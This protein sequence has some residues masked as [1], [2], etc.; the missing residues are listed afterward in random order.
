MFIGVGQPLNYAINNYNTFLSGYMNGVIQ[1]ISH[2][3][4]LKWV[5]SDV[6][7]DNIVIKNAEINVSKNLNGNLQKTKFNYEPYVLQGE[8]KKSVVAI[9]FGSA[10]SKI[11]LV[12]NIQKMYYFWMG[13]PLS[14][15]AFTI[16]LLTKFED[17][18]VV[19]ML[20]IISLL[21]VSLTV[22]MGI[23]IY[24]KNHSPIKV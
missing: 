18:V 2:Y 1:T 19:L 16:W 14:G 22:L 23:N 5:G 8:N 11:G 9:R 4:K 12:K 6:L 10:W 20:S 24:Q 13:L 3:R 7:I 21:C 15:A 17:S